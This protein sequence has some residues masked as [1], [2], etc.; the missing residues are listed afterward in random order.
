MPK[1]LVLTQTCWPPATQTLA[2]VSSAAYGAINR[3]GSS[4][5][6]LLYGRMSREVDAAALPSPVLA[7]QLSV[8]RMDRYTYSWT[9]LQ[10]L[11][12]SA[13]A[14]P[15]TPPNGEP[16]TVSVER[17]VDAPLSC[18]PPEMV[19]PEPDGSLPTA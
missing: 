13:R 2:S 12:G 14:S 4:P 18:R 15:P 3:A 7:L 11:A 5:G 6:V 16:I 1:P 9:C 10:P 17:R 8:A 19:T